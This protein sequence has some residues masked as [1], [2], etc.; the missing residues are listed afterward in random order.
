MNLLRIQFAIKFEL[1]ISD[2]F[3][4]VNWQCNGHQN[5]YM[6]IFNSHIININY[7]IYISKLQSVPSSQNVP[8]KEKKCWTPK[9]DE[10]LG[11][12]CDKS[13][14]LSRRKRVEVHLPDWHDSS[15]RRLR[16]PATISIGRSRP[17]FATIAL[18]RWCRWQCEWIP[19]FSRVF[20]VKWRWSDKKC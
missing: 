13:G 2:L 18:D 4:I 8:W 6:H 7:V 3:F 14:K 15:F 9:K 10:C 5:F 11:S 16:P 1:I 20:I 19:A 12:P 17:V